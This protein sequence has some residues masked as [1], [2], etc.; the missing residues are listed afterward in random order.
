MKNSLF[1]KI[2]SAFLVVMLALA[3]LP[4]QNAFAAVTR[5]TDWTSVGSS[6]GNGTTLSTSGSYAAAAGT[7]RYTLLAVTVVNTGATVTSTVSGTWG[8]V[9]FNSNTPTRFIGQVGNTTGRRVIYLFGFNEADIAARANDTITINSSLNSA[10]TYMH[11]YMSTYAGV[12]QT[13]SY[14]FS[15]DDNG[16]GN[17]TT[18]Q[19]TS[20]LNTINGSYGASI[21]LVGGTTGGGVT[22]TDAAAN[23]NTTY[24]MNVNN[25]QVGTASGTYATLGTKA[26]TGTATTQPT[27]TFSNNRNVLIGVVLAPS[28]PNTTTVG[29]ATATAASTTSINVSMPYTDD[30]NANN[31]YT[32][33]YKLSSAVGWTNWVTNAAHTASPYT[34]TITGLSAATSYDVRVTYNDATD[35]VT[36][37]NP[38]TINNVT[39]LT[40]TFDTSVRFTGNGNPLT[41]SYTVG[42]G[43]D[44]LVVSIVAG[45]NTARTGG[46]PTYNSIALTQA[47]ANRTAN[48]TVTEMWYLTNPPNGAAYNISIPNNGGLNLYATA[49]SYFAQSGYTFALDVANGNTNG[50]SANP[51]V[52]VTT[53][54]N[55]DVIVGAMGN[56]GNAA[57]TGRSGTMLYENDNGFFSDN[58]QYFYQTTAGAY[59]TSWTI[60]ADDWGVVVAAF[61]QVPT[62]TTVGTATA[63]A[64]SSTTINVSMPYT[65]DNNANNTYTVEYKLSSAGG[66]TNWITNAT[67]TASPYT[68]TITGLSPASNYDVRVT[69]NDADGVTGTNPQTINNVMTGLTDTS[70][71]FTGNGNPLTQSYTV[72]SGGD[73]LVVSIVAGGN[74]ART[75]GAP[76]YN[77][78]ALT[79]ADANRTAT[80]TVTEM[81]YLTNPPNGAAYNISIPNNG[82]LNLYATASSYFAQSGYTFALDVANGNTNGNSAN[83]SVSVTTTSNG[84]VIVGA[85]GN[86][87][88]TAPTGRSGTMLYENDNG[89]FSDNSQYFYQTTAGAYATSW[90]IGA[91]DWG[92]VVAAFKQTILPN[93]TTV[94]T[95]TAIAAS[96]TTINVSMPYTDDGNLNN[97]YTVDYKLSSAGGWTNWITNA[98]H[99]SSPYA[100]TITGLL[101]SSDYDVRVTYNDADGVTGTNPQ[102]ISNI[103]T[104]AIPISGSWT[105]VYSGTGTT[106]VNAVSATSTSTCTAG[107]GSNRVVLV[108]FSASAAAAANSN[109]SMTVPTATFGGVSVT[110]ITSTKASTDL[111]PHAWIGY[112]KEANIPAGAQNISITFTKGG[113]NNSAIG[114]ISIFCATFTNVDQTS[115]YSH[116]AVGPNAAFQ[117]ASPTISMNVGVNDQAILFTPNSANATVN[118]YTPTSYSAALYFANAG[119]SVDIAH[120]TIPAT[121]VTGENTSVTWSANGRSSILGVTLKR[122]P[123]KLDQVITVGTAAPANAAFGTTFPVD[124]TSDSGL[125]VAITTSGGCSG[126]GTSSAVI[127]M[128]SGTTACVVHYNQA[129]DTTYNAAPEVTSSTTAQKATATIT[130]NAAPTPTYLGGNFTV[131]ASTDNTDSSTLTY[132][133]VS[134]PCAFVSGATFSSSGAGTCVV[135][136][137]GAATANFNAASQTQN[138]SIAKATATV[139]LGSLA[140]TY[141]GTPKSATATTT[142]NG[143]TVDFTYNGS[144]TAPTNAGSYT[145]VG[146]INDANYV[147]TSTDT[148]VISKATATVTLGSLAQT[149]DGTPKSATATTTPNGLTVDFTYNGSPT[150]PTNAG[151][152]TIVGTVNDPNYTGSSTDTL[153]IAKAT[154]T[155]TL[156]SLA[157]TYDGTPKS[158]TATTTPN[159]LTVDFTYNGSPTAPT[160]A[161]SYTVVGTINDANYVG[162]STDT[163]VISKA[164]ATITLGSLAQTY[165]G[166]PKSATATTTPNGLTVDFTYDGSPTAP[167]NAGS[168]TVV[169]TINDANYVGTST[170]T[171]VISKATATVTL[172]SLA[173][174]YDG[175]PKSAT[176]ATTPNGLTVDFTYNGSPTAPTNA[177]SYTVVG[178]VNDPNYVGTSTDTLVISKAA[179]TVTLGSLAQTYDGT[180]KS[181][182]AVTNPLALTVD[183]T[184]DGSPTAPTNSG[185]YTV[186]GTINDANYVGTSTDT[187]VISKATA[188]VTLG[189]LAQ[190]YDGTPKSATA[191]TTPNGLT[192]DLTYN[193]SPTAPTNA[194]GYTVVG[195]INDPNYVGT[196]TDTLVISKATATVTLGSLAQTYDGTPKSATATTTPNG[197]TVDFTYNG[198]PTAPT[199]AGSYTVIG[200]INDVNYAGSSTDTLVISKAAATVTLGSLA[201][202]YDGTPKS[203]TATTTPNGLTVDFTYNGSPTA[204]INAGSYT[205]VGT[206]NDP[207]YAGSST[208]TLVISKATATVTLGSLA[209]T[210]DGTPKSATATTTPNG[211]TVD[212]TY[213]GSPT[214]PTN[215]GSYTVIGTINDAN[216]VGTSTDTL[217]I[218]KANQNISFTTPAPVGALVGGPAYTP[219]ASSTSSLSV[220]IT[221]DAASAAVCSISSGDVSFFG[222]GTCTINAN[223]AGD[224]NYNPA[225]QA[226]QAFGVG[227]GNQVITMTSTAPAAAV[228]SG[229]V[230]TPSAT[231]GPSGNPVIFTIDA[232]AASVCSISSGD[233]SF[234]AVGTCVVN[235]NQAGSSTYAAA[236]QVQQ[237]FAVGKGTP[238]VSWS[239]P[240]DITY[241]TPLS[242]IQLNATASVP[243]TFT[244]N[245]VLN[246]VLGTGAGQVLSVDFTPTDSANYLNVNGTT[247]TINV[248]TANP[249]LSVTNSPVVYNGSPQ[250]AIV[251]GS[252]PGTVSNILYNGSIN[253]P[254]NP[255]T[256][257]ITADFAPTDSVNYNNLTAASAGDFIINSKD[258]DYPTFADVPMNHWA[259]AY[260]ESI[261]AAGITAGCGTNPLIYCPDEPITRAQMAIFI[262]RG[263]HGKTYVPPVASGT[264]FTDVPTDYWAADWIEQLAEEGITVG[265]GDGNYCPENAITRAEMSIFLLRSKLGNTHTPPPATGT[266]FN[267][268]PADHWAASWIEQ[269]AFMEITSGCGNGAFCPEGQVTRDQM[270]VFIQRM[271]EFPLP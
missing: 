254:K 91:D 249:T 195:T 170:D 117:P 49:S 186:V 12:S 52:S 228:V 235:A 14:T 244:Y 148:L 23:P 54:A 214:A 137:N 158:A 188:T 51:S 120:R 86:G 109:F 169:G 43:G 165:D 87:G 208:D 247:V 200:T 48:E 90:T 59:A 88:N 118:N 15:S 25:V 166:T 193:G 36:G 85:M 111:R 198:S 10:A 130:F 32:V 217:V 180:P 197:L 163:L 178:T 172:G 253:Q 242:A 22:N 89:A 106:V 69:Y 183:F 271:F 110:E 187:L 261:Y 126:S 4:V 270:A 31:T 40:N 131:S 227:L 157:Q 119:Y 53:T 63:T 100:T 107:A 42:S 41:Q 62:T 152:Y 140:Q 168:Y 129:G 95:A 269:L 11:S 164:T 29:T 58:S 138:V 258:P 103:T 221:I 127:T 162:T 56:G 257:S 68:T 256:Y 209:Q 1:I 47:D 33:D 3:M 67:H 71:R 7:Q 55:G 9:A 205:V 116:A 18:A 176:A 96:S 80:E 229:P 201:Q 139:T 223:Q 236:S 215:A 174:T 211:L 108:A 102:T 122:A 190:T 30:G 16:G 50:N 173:Q 167:T 206:V 113:T 124:A 35:G 160:N 159:G 136:A 114:N 245:P 239:N 232:S 252:V 128:T 97:T 250:A 246:S 185:S 133:Y 81:W 145:V 39:T 66:W 226:Q 141:D 204:P 263:V 24:A 82:G 231:G 194:G 64:A 179:A 196:S 84:D 248:L 20:A 83:P 210:Y 8:S 192:V 38:Q 60:G 65:V 99:T 177:G 202:T 220:V 255:G 230:Y 153:V 2:S 268:V 104:P 75:G 101:P 105:N 132:S 260:V 155:V 191:T 212:F 121:A 28:L 149:Y 79:Q 238:I 93:T 150:A 213:N 267:D 73:L 144:P 207:N 243:G 224:A 219:S 57:P 27:F 216:Y 161:G 13:S 218:A 182:S 171:L 112:I 21:L 76:T 143:L 154:A 156:G 72:G 46:A 251:V 77:G 142:P 147:G 151:S 26:F 78:I 175:T 234:Q 203:A 94:G 237:S 44:L 222:T 225:P 135:Q 19:Y 265:C 5:P 45:G 233:V 74:T 70:V 61:K 34:T 6:V 240:A 125:N 264:V 189:S 134:G 184:Y 262:L 199:N 241:G 259:W 266:T 123:D 98:A 92:V 115:V 37:T 181:A 17:T 146:T